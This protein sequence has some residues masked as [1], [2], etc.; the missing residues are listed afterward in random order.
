MSGRRE[1]RD[2][3][4]QLPAHAAFGGCGQLRRVPTFLQ[5]TIVLCTAAAEASQLTY[6]FV[7]ETEHLRSES[8]VLSYLFSTGSERTRAN[9]V[10]TIYSELI[11]SFAL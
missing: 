3:Q 7:T 9:L 5:V 2:Y 4:L 6:V 8:A 1:P 11:K 10:T